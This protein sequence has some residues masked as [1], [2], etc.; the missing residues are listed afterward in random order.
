MTSVLKLEA[1]VRGWTRLLGSIGCMGLLLGAALITLD[2]LMRWIANAP[3]R[4]MSDLNQLIF[5]VG[6]AACFP[7][8]VAE[9]A[10]ITFRMLGDALGKRSAGWLDVFGSAALLLFVLLV[11]WQL[12]VYTI[13]LAQSGR[14]TWQ[15]RIP[16]TPCW[17]IATGLVL[18]CVPVQV[19]AL[20]VDIL[21]AAKGEV[22][23]RAEGT[24]ISLT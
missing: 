22:S 13:E 19:A 11:G 5:V 12:V 23:G 17:A 4:G 9:R 24:D 16:V 18:L 21:H 8:V 10:N 14:T 6:I 2:V 3:I 15:L 7:V 1:V 20:L